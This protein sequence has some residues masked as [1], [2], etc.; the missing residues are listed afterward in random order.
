MFLFFSKHKLY[1]KEKISPSNKEG[2]NN[3]NESISAEEIRSDKTHAAINENVKIQ[4]DINAYI[5]K[6]L[7]VEQNVKDT[8]KAL[9][10]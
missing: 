6:F 1:D 9:N 3:K 4:G 5:R 8:T 7:E 2:N 10:K